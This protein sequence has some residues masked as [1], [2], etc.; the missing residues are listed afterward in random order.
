MIHEGLNNCRESLH[1]IIVLNENEM[2]ISKNGGHFAGALLKM[3][4]TGW[5]FN[6]KRRVKKVLSKTLFGQKVIRF[7]SRQKARIKRAIYDDNYFEQLGMNYL[8]PIDGHDRAKLELIFEEAKKSEGCTVVHVK[9]VKGRATSRQKRSRENTTGFPLPENS[10]FPH[11][12]SIS[13][14]PLHLWATGTGRS[15]RLRPP[16]RTAPD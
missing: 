14:R 7:S 9:T 4:T 5:Y 11:S 2:S 15:V 13:A 12:R 16:W 8:G 3:R 10:R 1:L 6:L